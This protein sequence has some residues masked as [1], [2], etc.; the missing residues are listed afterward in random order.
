[1]KKL[2]LFLACSVMFGANAVAQV[3]LVDEVK[4]EIGGM[5]AN[6]DKFKAGAQKIAA[7]LTNPETEKSAE[8]WLVAA[9]ANFGIYDKMTENKL[10]GKEFDASAAAKAL[11]KGQQYLV[12]ALPLDSV[13]E[14]EKDGTPK[15]DKKT[16]AIKY[17]TKFSKDIVT[18]LAGRTMDYRN[19]GGEAF[20]GG[21]KATAYD[22][23]EVY[24][25][26]QDNPAYK[27][28]LQ[29]DPDTIVGQFR[30]YQG[31]AAWQTDRYPEAVN[32]FMKAT[33][34]GYDTQDC[35]DYALACA[36][37][38]EDEYATYYSILE[39][40]NDKFGDKD[41][42]YMNDLINRYIFEK[43]YDK[44]DAL[45]DKALATNPN[46]AELLNLKGSLLD[47]KDQGEE[48]FKYFEKAV[49]IDPTSVNAQVNYANYF[50]K[51][52]DKITAENSTLNDNA[53]YPMVAPL[54]EKAVP[55]LETALKNNTDNDTVKRA[56]L[57]I[58]Y[59]LSVQNQDY[60]KKYEELDKQ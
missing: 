30:F 42:K 35:Y 53:L 56:L 52:A 57:N 45:L 7:A 58:Y 10:L 46:N 49:S 26:N 14:L 39:K 29:A 38:I 6:L 33:Q 19:A 21:D 28:K 51:K 27:G 16:G 43:T 41:T 18:L 37:K 3:K 55:A 1:M 12:K 48:A 60:A 32:A 24:A 2:A 25:E 23:W 50:L 31:I 44:A 22:L 4:K 40:A 17:K 59:K 8:A 20:D 34:K 36:V 47:A 11:L 54:Y 15:R 13:T 9:K 5:G